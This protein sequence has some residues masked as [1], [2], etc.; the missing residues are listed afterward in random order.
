[1]QELLLLQGNP[2]KRRGGK[3]RRSAAQRAATRKML[4]ANRNPAKRRSKRAKSTAVSA[5]ARRSARRGARRS[6]SRGVSSS[7]RGM[8]GG[9]LA[10]V[11]VGAVAGGGAILNDVAMGLLQKAMPGTA[12]IAGPVN[13]DGTTN[14]V[15]FAAKGFTAYA[16][17]K[18]LPLRIAPQLGAGAMT[19]L[20]YQ[21][22]RG[23]IPAGRVPMGFY[24]PARIANM[25][26]VKR[27]LPLSSGGEGSNAASAMSMARMTSNGTRSRR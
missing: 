14:Y 9:I 20:A 16:M 24:N 3:K 5:P 6:A 27:I 11:K 25:G 26:N 19:V 18:Y 23:M 7:F 22:L 21:L 2:S 15:Y 4:A 10:M 8:G 17:A 12:A 13:D 1:M